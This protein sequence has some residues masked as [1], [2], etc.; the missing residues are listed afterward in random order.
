MTTRSF[1]LHG[2]E[3]A[4]DGPEDGAPIILC[5]GAGEQLTHWPDALISGLA[6]RGFRIVRFDARDTGL[7]LRYDHEWEADLPTLFAGLMA[8]RT[9][10]LPYTLIDMADD[11]V[12][13]MD[14]LTLTTAHL[15]GVSLGG[16]QSQLVAARHPH[17][18]ASLTSIMSNSG[19]PALPPPDPDI[20]AQ[21]MSAPA[22]NA[23]DEAK[24]EHFIAVRSLLAGSAYHRDAAEWRAAAERSLARNAAPAGTVRQIAASLATRERYGLLRSITAPTLVIHGADDPVM[25]VACAEDTANAITGARCVVIPGMGHDVPAALTPVLVALIAEHAAAADQTASSP[26]RSRR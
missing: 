19:N 15:V 23:D 1:K 26:L 18:V 4:V 2:I 10:P 16:M 8:G 3:V 20:A 14:G 12:G 22:A 13:I 11:I 24:I 21:L 9:I 5:M 17:R 7:S 6:A 25:P